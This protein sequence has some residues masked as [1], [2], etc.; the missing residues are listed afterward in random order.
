MNKNFMN[1][2]NRNSIKT[3]YYKSNINKSDIKEFDIKVWSIIKKIPRGKI[4]TY[5]MIAEKLNTK[6]YRRIGLACKRSPGIKKGIPCHRVVN[7]K[8]YLHGFNTG[9]KEKKLLLE[10]EGIKLK[11]KKT[12]NKID[13]KIK[14]FENKLFKL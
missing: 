14:D 7:S 12:K 9:I 1:K 4:V 8:G 10:K 6:N 13:Y 3:K 5:K 2:T 11:R